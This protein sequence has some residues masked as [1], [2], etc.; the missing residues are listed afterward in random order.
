MGV[1]VDIAACV[2]PVVTQLEDCSC[3]FYNMLF[4]NLEKL[5]V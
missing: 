1:F 4:V 5:R 2:L 3:F